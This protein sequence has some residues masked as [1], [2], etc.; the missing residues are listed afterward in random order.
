MKY[1]LYAGG[2]NLCLRGP[3]YAHGKCVKEAWQWCL[4][5]RSTIVSGRIVIG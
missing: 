2:A 5:T 1:R 4:I 3:H